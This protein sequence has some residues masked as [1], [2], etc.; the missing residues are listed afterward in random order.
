M[1]AWSAAPSTA[2]VPAECQHSPSL[3]VVLAVLGGFGSL[4][5]RSGCHKVDLQQPAAKDSSIRA[6]Q[7]QQKSK[8]HLQSSERALLAPNDALDSENEFESLHVLAA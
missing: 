1:Q 4:I 8:I 5:G 6:H 7:Q 3:W 2:A